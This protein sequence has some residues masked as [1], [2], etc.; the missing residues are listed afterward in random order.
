MGYRGQPPDGLRGRG[1]GAHVLRAQMSV[2]SVFHPGSITSSPLRRIVGPTIR[3]PTALRCSPARR[4]GYGESG[5]LAVK[6][7]E[8]LGIASVVV[9]DVLQQT[10]DGE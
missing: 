4:A 1:R 5:L 3:S 9:E 10:A 6:I 8:D 2:P 7:L